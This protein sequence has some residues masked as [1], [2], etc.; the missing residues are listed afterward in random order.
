MLQSLHSLKKCSKNGKFHCSKCRKFHHIS[1]C[2]AYQ[3]V[4][5]YVHQ[6]DIQTRDFAHFQTS[7]NRITEPN[8]LKKLA[9]RI[10]DSGSQSS[11]IHTSL[12]V[13]LQLSIVIKR[14]VLISPFENNDPTLHSRRLVQFTLHVIW[15]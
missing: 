13:H 14:N 11:F 12:L 4:C 5:T 9:R 2:N 15:A 10:L 8:G 7:R 3:P 1:I 6:I